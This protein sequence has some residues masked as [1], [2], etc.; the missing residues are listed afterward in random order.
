[1]RRKDVKTMVTYY[2]GIPSMIQPLKGER[3]ELESQ[4]D[5]LRG[6]SYDGAPHSSSPGKPTEELAARLDERNVHNRLEEI[7]VRESV[8]LM[9]R[10]CIRGCMDVLRGEYK[11]LLCAKYRDGCS[12]TKIS[13]R[14]GKPERTVRRWHDRAL[15]RLGEALEEMPMADEILARASRARV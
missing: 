3:A 12:W 2:F 7:S 15:D 4:Y 9:D 5:S 1:M 10:E 14:N 11:M 6:M 8:L 13:V